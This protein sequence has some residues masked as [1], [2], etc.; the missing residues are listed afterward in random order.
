[1]ISKKINI[2][3]LSAD[4]TQKLGQKIGTLIK[5]PLIIALR[6]DLGS[7]KTAFVQGLAKGLEVPDGYYIT[8]PTFTL[9]NE[10]P[11]RLSLVHVDLYRLES[12]DDL[13][14]LGLDELLYGQAVIAIEWAEKLI[15]RQPAE[16]LLVT[17]EIIDDECRKLTLDATGHDEVNLIRALEDALSG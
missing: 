12:I 3:T 10:Y 5:Q 17:M 16:Q 2:K 7:G 6:G 4:E 9:I 14:D 1:M 11:G 13:E 15:G 8:S